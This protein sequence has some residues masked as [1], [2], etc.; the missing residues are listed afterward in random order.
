ME[1]IAQKYTFPGE[2]GQVAACSVVGTTVE[3]CKFQEALFV[4]RY[5]V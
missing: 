2:L 1:P 3:Y 5:K 4:G